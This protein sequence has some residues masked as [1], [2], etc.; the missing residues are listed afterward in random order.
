MT[1]DILNLQV[2]LLLFGIASF[3]GWFVYIAVLKKEPNCNSKIWLVLSIVAIILQAHLADIL[4]V[5]HG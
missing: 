3:I 2:F 4:R 5:Y 1:H